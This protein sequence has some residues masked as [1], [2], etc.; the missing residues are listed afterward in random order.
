MILATLSNG[1]ETSAAVRVGRNWHP[2]SDARDLS[3]LLRDAGWHLRA[4]EARRQP[5]LDLSHLVFVNPLPS[6]HKV[7]CCGLNYRD[8]IEETGRD[9]PTHPTLFAKFADTLIGP[10]EDIVVRGSE[11]VDWEAELAIVIG[12]EVHRADARAAKG[13]IFGYT[14]CNDV[15]MRD[16]QSRTLQWLQGKA[17]D[18]TTPLGPVVVTSDMVDPALGLE[19][20][21]E[22][23]GEVVQEGNTRNLVFDAPNLV[24]YVSQF[25]TLRPGDIIL[26][27]TPGGVGMGMTPPRYLADGDVLTTRVEGVGVLRNTVRFA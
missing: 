17:W 9:I 24:S 3:E 10:T 26:S 23:N 6:P 5:S 12:R 18:R 16:W 25:T 4:T 21:C 2:I 7:I 11:R 14:V 27:G 13:A 20:T 8:H 15:S 22:V 19:V 1:V